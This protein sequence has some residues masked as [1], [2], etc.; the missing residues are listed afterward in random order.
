[1][2]ILVVMGFVSDGTSDGIEVGS[3]DGLVLGYLL[4]TDDGLELG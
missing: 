4:G 2:M 3:S 1:M